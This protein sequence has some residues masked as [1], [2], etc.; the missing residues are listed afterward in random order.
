[1]SAQLIDLIKITQESDDTSAGTSEINTTGLDLQGYDGVVFFTTIATANA[2]NYLALDQGATSTPTDS[3]EGS[4]CVAG[5]DGD[6]VAVDLHKPLYRYVRASVIRGASTAVGEIYAIR[7][8]GRKAPQS[9]ADV[10]TKVVSPAN[11]SV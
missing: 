11:G 5:S 9:A 3:V 2:G 7:Y 1:M 6:V 8:K 10:V 4:S